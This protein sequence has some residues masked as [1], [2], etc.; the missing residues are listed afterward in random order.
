VIWVANSI[1]AAHGVAFG[2]LPYAE[3]LLAHLE[4]RVATADPDYVAR[5][6]PA[7]DRPSES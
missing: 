3:Q 7:R 2:R 4:G 5:P 1:Q 6:A